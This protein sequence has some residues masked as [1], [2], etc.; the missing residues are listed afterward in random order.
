MQGSIENNNVSKFRMQRQVLGISTQGR[1]ADTSSHLQ[2]SKTNIYANQYR[3]FTAKGGKNISR[4]T[5]HIDNDL[6]IPGAS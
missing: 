1:I 4:T 5:A 6:A 2:G 3:W